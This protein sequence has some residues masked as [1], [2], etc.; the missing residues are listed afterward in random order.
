M[1]DE[2]LAE[3]EAP[4]LR[5]REHSH[6]SAYSI[7]TEAGGHEVTLSFDAVEIQR[8]RI[9]LSRQVPHSPAGQ[10]SV[11]ASLEGRPANFGA[12]GTELLR[13]AEDQ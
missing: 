8:N 12:V 3:H 6:G 10:Q 1:N 5:L 11:A 9:V 13:I 7:V 4:R 2:L